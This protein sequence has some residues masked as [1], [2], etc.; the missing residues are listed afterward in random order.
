MTTI[1]NDYKLIKII[2]EGA[3]GQVWKGRHVITR[4]EVAIKLEKKNIRQM[5]KYETIILRHLS[6]IR[7]VVNIKYY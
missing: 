7:N 4:K 1:I 6:N 5:L 3:Y 2:G